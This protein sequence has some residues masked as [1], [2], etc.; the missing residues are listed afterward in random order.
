MQGSLTYIR[1]F[2]RAGVDSFDSYPELVNFVQVVSEG[3][4]VSHFI[5]HARKCLLKGLNPHQNRTIPPLRYEWVWAL[6]RDFPHL[7]FSLNGGVLRLEEVVA[8]LAIVNKSDTTAFDSH[9]TTP[10][11]DGN[12]RAGHRHDGLQGVMV[13]RA[14]YNMPWD[15]LG[16]R[17][18]SRCIVCLWQ[19]LVANTIASSCSCLCASHAGNADRAVFGAEVN[20]AVSRRQVL[21]DYAIWAD[22][23]IGRWRIDEDGHKS[24]NVG[25]SVPD[26]AV[27][28]VLVNCL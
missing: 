23:M 16:A 24:P 5:V 15:V 7:D 12:S 6:K 22:G 25:F 28:S 17:P 20:A 21:K 8:A 2:V 9:G 14:A 13:G 18:K 10:A 27:V 26:S 11:R 3:S 19:G 4:G 1:W